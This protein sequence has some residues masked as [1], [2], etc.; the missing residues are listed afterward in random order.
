MAC[1]VCS[2]WERPGDRKCDMLALS[3]A[4]LGGFLGLKSHRKRGVMA[5]RSGQFRAIM[6]RT[7][8]E[9]TRAIGLVVGWWDGVLGRL[10]FV[11]LGMEAGAIPFPKNW[12]EC[13]KSAIS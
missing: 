3:M 13:L 8:Q 12:E 1:V 11:L 7:L 4:A 10:P 6:S 5:P 2:L 9:A